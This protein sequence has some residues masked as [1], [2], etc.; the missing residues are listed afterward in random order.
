MH[1]LVKWP[2]RERKVNVE[3]AAAGRGR[4]RL[5]PTKTPDVTTFAAATDCDC[6]DSAALCPPVYDA[7]LGQRAGA[8]EGGLADPGSA[9]R[10]GGLAHDGIGA[11]SV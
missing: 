11:G 6:R 1:G 7:D 5:K 3:L 8:V 4:Y 9:H 2:V 10:H